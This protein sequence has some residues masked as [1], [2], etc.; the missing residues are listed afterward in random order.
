M[1]FRSLFC[2]TLLAACALAQTPAPSAAL[3][4]TPA[5]APAAA[6]AAQAATAGIDETDRLMQEYMAQRAQWMVLRQDALEKAA[7]APN[8]N[9]RKG[10]LKKLEDDE[11]PLLAKMAVARKALRE[12]KN[13]KHG[14]DK[15][16]R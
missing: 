9:A 13:N 11:Q 6:P 4:T 8:E 12:S 2:F 10:V 5:A 3:A 7:K 1:N 15:P 14:G 16:R